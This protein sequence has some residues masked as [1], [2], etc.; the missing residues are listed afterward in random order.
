VSYSCVYES[1]LFYNPA[2]KHSVIRV[3]TR[4]KTVPDKARKAANGRDDFIR[5]IAKGYNLPQ[6]DKI[7]MIL[8][9]EWQTGKY[10]TQL[11]VEDCEEIVPYTDE[12]LKGYLSSCLVKGIGEKTA[13][14]IIKRFGADTLNIIENSPEKLLEIKGI[15]E[16]KLEDIKRTFNESY[17]VRSLMMLLSP[18]NISVTAATHIYD[19]FGAKSI[20]ILTDN[21]YE[22]CNIPGFGFKR[23]DAIVKKGDTP[24]NSPMRIRGAVITALETQKQDNGHLFIDERTLVQTTAEMLNEALPSADLLVKTAEI[25]SVIDNMILKGDIV[26][27]EGRIY[28][29]KS[30]VLENETA[31]RIGRLLA[32]P[33][34]KIDISAILEHVRKNLGIALSDKQS[35]AVYMAFSSNLSII[36]GSPGTGKTTVLKAIIEVYKALYP[37]EKIK[38]AAP[39]GR[40]SRRMAESTGETDASTLHSMLGLQN[41]DGYF[42]KDKEFEPIGAGLIIVDESSMIDMWLA[43]Q[44]FMR[45]GNNT[46]I[47]LVGD[48]DQLQS[49]GAGDVFRQ[50]INSGL[51]PVTVLDKIFRQKD[52]SRIAL[53]A[54]AINNDQTKLSYGDDFCF[55]K[56]QTQ[57]Q[58]ADIIKRVFCDL[59]E[60][61]GIENV[62]ILSPYRKKG[63]A[64][65]NELNL[66]IREIVN[67][68]KGGLPDLRIGADYFRVGDKV[69]QNKN[70]SKASNGDIGFIRDI[71]TDKDNKAVITI[72]FSA[73]RK[74]EYTL[75][76]MK[77]IELAY[78]TTV[79]KAMGSEYDIV[80]MPIIKSHYNMLNRNLVYTGITRAKHR[81][82][83]VGQPSMLCMAIHRNET[84]NR[85]TALAERIGNYKKVYD[86]K[87]K[88]AG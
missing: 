52:G 68:Y 28:S 43:R 67:P 60:K 56:C 69:M 14:D 39:T 24:L 58:A 87:M 62:Q 7:S 21:P 75:E 35:E 82:I 71:G 15:S 59:T 20:D 83:L 44:F 81:V 41:E 84:G 55:Y 50:L 26:S 61:Y 64:A 51:I 77:N 23:V 18:F 38:L 12:G 33:P 27:N 6:T 86:I 17:S 76:D 8:E 49:V 13:D 78:A 34:K 48:P 73:D 66:A 30:F 22:L 10:G 40:A 85:N 46:K 36:T 5:F 29:T 72:E 4:D 37:K 1:T 9:G 19:Y 65:A 88:K 47:V 42:K 79:H 31:E 70:N 57:D 74:A 2:D 3:R 32:M 45:I 25:D 54:R 63:A 53:N 11:S 80:I 16:Q